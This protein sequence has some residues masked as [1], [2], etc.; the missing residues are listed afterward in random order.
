VR[1]DCIRDDDIRDVFGSD[2]VFGSGGNLYGSGDTPALG[3]AT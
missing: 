2:D 3:A 1:R